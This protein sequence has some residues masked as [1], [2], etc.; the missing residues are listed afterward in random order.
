MCSLCSRKCNVVVSAS[1]FRQNARAHTCVS[2]TADNFTRSFVH[3]R[4]Q[5]ILRACVCASVYPRHICTCENRCNVWRRMNSTLSNNKRLSR[6]QLPR[7]S[8]ASTQ[9]NTILFGTKH[10][11]NFLAVNADREERLSFAQLLVKLFKRISL[12]VNCRVSIERQLEERVTLVDY[13]RCQ[14]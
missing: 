12:T 13:I 2:I 6:V 4:V 10:T 11:P 14:A 8:L 7:P 1:K 9:R 3:C 5:V